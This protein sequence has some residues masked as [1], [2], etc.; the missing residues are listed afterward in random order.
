MIG[1]FI[2]IGKG[3]EYIATIYLGSPLLQASFHWYL[4]VGA[5]LFSFIIHKYLKTSFVK[6]R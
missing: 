3:V 2:G 4:I 1:I 5:L 6:K